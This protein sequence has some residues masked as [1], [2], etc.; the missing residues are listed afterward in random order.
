M[1]PR[2]ATCQRSPGAGRQGRNDGSRAESIRR[3]EC[4]EEN[5]AG[6]AG[7]RKTVIGLQIAANVARQGIPTI[8][9]AVEETPEDMHDS[10]DMLGL[11]ITELVRDG[12]LH[13]ANIARPMDGPT[14][15]P[16]SC[17]GALRLGRLSSVA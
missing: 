14:V 5:R 2:S 17:A 9:L 12:L 10:G 16:R 4:T 15:R 3:N 1:N 7:P 11:G 13:F 8:V 6:R